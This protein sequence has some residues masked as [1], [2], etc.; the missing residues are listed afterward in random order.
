MADSIEKKYYKI[1]E[2]SEIL[3]IPQPTLRFWE[4]QFTVIKPRR[5]DKGTRFYTAY[6]IEKIKMVRYL[7]K[8]R[9]FKIE[10][11]Q[12]IITHNHSGVSKH[13]QAIERLKAIRT[14]LLKLLQA[15]DNGR[16]IGKKSTSSSDSSPQPLTDNKND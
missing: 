16:R 12:E 5:N 13:Y 6:D 8:E 14:D 9:G 15:I 2:V 1:S 3:G 10:K 11:A 7:V 4:T